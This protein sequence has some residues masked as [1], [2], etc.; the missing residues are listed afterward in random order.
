MDEKELR[1]IMQWHPD[2]DA[3]M[4]AYLEA[5]ITIE[6]GEKIAKNPAFSNWLRI[7][8]G[9][10]PVYAIERKA[11]VTEPGRKDDLRVLCRVATD[12]R[13]RDEV[14]IRFE[15]LSRYGSKSIPYPHLSRN[16]S[17][18]VGLVLA[19]GHLSDNVLEVTNKD[20][21]IIQRF[22]KL[23]EKIFDIT[24]STLTD[25]RG[26]IRSRCYNRSLIMVLHEAFEVPFGNKSKIFKIPEVIHS[27]SEDHVKAFLRAYLEA[28]G[29]I[30]FN[31]RSVE[32]STS[33][34]EA[35]YGLANLFLRLGLQT[36]LRKRKT[37]AADSF[38]LYLNGKSKTLKLMDL[39]L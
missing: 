6:D 35:A 25:N 13:L 18:F 19:E 16:L 4:L 9:E 31:S 8:T 12:M 17:E 26:L 34:K 24:P 33:S 14:P 11:N 1:F 7:W 2:Q 20:P 38:R 5:L 22:K 3:Q 10:Y 36:T 37:A 29:H 30:S 27:S 32:V 15:G 23:S 21:L 28:E 39:G